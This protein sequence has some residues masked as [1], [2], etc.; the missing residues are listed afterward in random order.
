MDRNI[1]L[2]ECEKQFKLLVDSKAE[3][4]DVS[5]WAYEKYQLPEVKKLA[6]TDKVVEEIFDRLLMAAT[7]EDLN[8]TTLY[9]QEDFKEWWNDYLQLKAEDGDKLD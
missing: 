6:E 4:S 3:P 1:L 9:S 8:G 7:P 5:H 2:L